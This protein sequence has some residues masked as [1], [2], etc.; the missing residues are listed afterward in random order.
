MHFPQLFPFLLVAVDWLPVCSPL[1]GSLSWSH[2]NRLLTVLSSLLIS[3][4][5]QRSVKQPTPRFPHTP[6]SKLFS[7]PDVFPWKRSLLS[8]TP[9][10]NLQFPAVPA[11]LSLQLC[12]HEDI[13][14]FHSLPSGTSPNLGKIS[15][16][17]K[18]REFFDLHLHLYILMN[19]HSLIKFMLYIS[20]KL[21]S[22]LCWINILDQ[23]TF[24]LEFLA[25]VC[26]SISVIDS[27]PVSTL[28]V[29]NDS[30][31]WE[32]LGWWPSQWVRES[33]AKP[34]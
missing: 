17:C 7:S 1:F 19:A 2:W 5:L 4:P 26:V 34:D 3:H 18:F 28:Q 27:D 30:T 24:F 15:F 13:Q 22:L 23:L 29:K 12:L 6:P 25:L 10:S 33:I 16:L 14:F 31:R 32:R 21:L 11:A 20:H 9:L 8:S